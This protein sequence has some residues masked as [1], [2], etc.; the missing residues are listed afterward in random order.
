MYH[1]LYPY[2]NSGFILDVGVLLFSPFLCYVTWL[3][4]I[5][6]AFV[7][8]DL[9]EETEMNHEILGLTRYRSVSRCTMIFD[10]VVLP[11]TQR[12]SLSTDFLRGFRVLY[13]PA[14][15][16][17]V[18]RANFSHPLCLG[19]TKPRIRWVCLPVVLSPEI[20]WQGREADNLV[21]PVS[22]LRKRWSLPPVFHTFHG[23]VLK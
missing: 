5:N 22:R 20:K 15:G 10:A 4:L 14:T 12:F 18:G 17:T 11:S 9:P 21:H 16:W 13:T 7:Y 6:R 23:L 2:L 1:K 3:W 8:W 19:P